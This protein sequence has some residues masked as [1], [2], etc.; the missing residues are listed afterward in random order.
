MRF[1][2]FRYFDHVGAAGQSRPT[3]EPGNSP[4]DR[5]RFEELALRVDGV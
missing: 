4:M 3:S 5:S 1:P 2:N